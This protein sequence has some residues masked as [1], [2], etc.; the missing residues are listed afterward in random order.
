MFSK[1]NGKPSEVTRRVAMDSAGR[2]GGQYPSEASSE[3]QWLGAL[4]DHHC[5][6]YFLRT[7]DGFVHNLNSPLQI[8]WMRSEQVLHDVVKLQSRISGGDTTDIGALADQMKQRMDSFMRGLDQLNEI[9]SFLSKNWLGKQRSEVGDVCVNKAVEDAVFL[10]KADMFFKHRVETQLKLDET[11]ARI[12]GRHSDLCVMV[13][14]LV[15]NALDAMLDSEEKS[16]TIQTACE[17]DHI[18]IHVTDTGMGISEQDSPHVFKPFFATKR[19]I[20]Y[21][22]KT[23]T[24]MGLGLSVVL[25]L[26]EDYNGTV[27]FASVPQ[28]TNF[29][30]KIPL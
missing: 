1:C 7:L 15:Q 5:G 12:K 20:E 6:V 14:H 13:L 22:G 30:V 18:V 23:E 4:A 24:R 21:N 25:R 10:L 8:I 28:K 9:L 19:E 2:T 17:E 26:L 27:S 11:L 16:L 29:I 3:R